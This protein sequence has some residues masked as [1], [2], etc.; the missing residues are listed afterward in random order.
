MFAFVAL[1]V[2]DRASQSLVNAHRLES[3][4]ERRKVD[5]GT[6]APVGKAFGWQLYT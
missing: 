6:G 5:A 4:P 3:P 2:I 1:G